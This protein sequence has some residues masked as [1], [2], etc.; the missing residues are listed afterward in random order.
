MRRILATILAAGSF[1]VGADCTDTL[2]L[3]AL[4]QHTLSFK[5]VRSN[6]WDSTEVPVTRLSEARSLSKLS[7]I[8]I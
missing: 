1:A 5:N 8:H 3:A 6:Q 2:F 7:L 4:K